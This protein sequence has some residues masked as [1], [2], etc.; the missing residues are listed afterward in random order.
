MTQTGNHTYDAEFFE[1]IS[2]GAKVSAEVVVGEMDKL[3][4]PFL[5][6]VIDVGC[7][8]GVWTAQFNTLP[9][10]THV[11]G[12]DGDYVDPSH[13]KFPASQFRPRDLRKPFDLDEKFGLAVCL[14]VGEHLAPDSGPALIQSL[15]QHAD[16]VLFSAAIPGQ[17][18]EHHSN[19]RPLEYWRKL[20]ASHGYVP[21]DCIRPIIASN[22][23][24]E[25]WYRYN[26]L[27]YVAG[28]RLEE[29]PVSVTNTVIP[30]QDSLPS[31]A[32][33]FWKLRCG[34]LGV[35]P[36]SVIEVLAAIKHAAVRRRYRTTAKKL[37]ND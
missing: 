16:L 20:F 31:H 19:E 32:S 4:G 30:A 6:S 13:L 23:N 15:T 36:R 17:G 9:Q 29:M 28:T 21:A 14:E 11:I 12:V 34:I 5:T 33:F 27:L 37:T 26:S 22:Q 10:V 3:V 24:V 7:G 35:L 1:Y 2:H 18:G 8:E 25:P